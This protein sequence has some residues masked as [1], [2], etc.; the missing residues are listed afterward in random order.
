M[1]IC[2]HCHGTGVDPGAQYVPAPCCICSG[3]GR[4]NPHERIPTP[5]LAAVFFTA[6]A[7]AGAITAILIGG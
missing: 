3:L 1:T 7:I 2:P 4:V 5:A 6:L